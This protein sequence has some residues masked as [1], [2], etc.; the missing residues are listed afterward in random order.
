M[1]T[2]EWSRFII[3]LRDK[4]FTEKEINDFILWIATGDLQYKPKKAEEAKESPF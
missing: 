1:E 2:Q 4:G 3:G